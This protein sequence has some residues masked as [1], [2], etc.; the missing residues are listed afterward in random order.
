MISGKPNSNSRDSIIP[1]IIA[2]QPKLYQL[3]K[4]SM[5]SLNPYLIGAVCLTYE[6][7]SLIQRNA[8]DELRLFQCAVT[9]HNGDPDGDQHRWNNGSKSA[10]KLA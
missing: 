9:T 6:G 1:R 2:Q 7:S 10:M 8:T 4:K 5:S 3:G